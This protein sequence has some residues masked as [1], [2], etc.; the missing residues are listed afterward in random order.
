MLKSGF[1]PIGDHYH[2]TRNQQITI[3]DIHWYKAV[4]YVLHVLLTSTAI[5]SLNVTLERL[6]NW[7]HMMERP[8]FCF[9]NFTRFY[10]SIIA[11]KLRRQRLSAGIVF[12]H[13][14][15]WA[16]RRNGR[17]G[18]VYLR[19]QVLIPPR[20]LV[21]PASCQLF[22]HSFLPSS[23]QLFAIH[24]TVQR[25]ESYQPGVSCKKKNY[26]NND[27]LQSYRSAERLAAW[28]ASVALQMFYRRPCF[29]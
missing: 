26:N 3:E 18:L 4:S 7:R 23:Q 1:G 16:P 19:K 10:L 17:H 12:L 24:G 29:G 6:Q 25:E 28:K 27:R 8:W 14:E 22:T 20:D 2:G 21:L 9:I 15:W 13:P 11:Y 5:E